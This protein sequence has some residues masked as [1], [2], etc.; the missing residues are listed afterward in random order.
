MVIVSPNGTVNQIPKT[1]SNSCKTAAFAISRLQA[2]RARL[3][4]IHRDT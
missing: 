4:R 2:A 1:S 3:R